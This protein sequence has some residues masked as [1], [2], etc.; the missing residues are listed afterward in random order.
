MPDKDDTPPP[1]GRPGLARRLAESLRASARPAATRPA[2]AAGLRTATATVA[3]LVVG[4][5]LGVPHA[6]WAGIAGFLVSRADGGGAYR[7]RARA[8]GS[9]ALAAAFAAASA[10][11]ASR[12]PAAAVPAVLV[13]TVAASLARAYGAAAG[14][15]GVM[16]SVLFVVSLSTPVSAPGEPLERA[17]WVLAG[18]AWAM[19][20]SLSFWP[21]R[22]YRPAVLAVA[23]CYRNLS[24]YAA[25]LAR[26]AEGGGWGGRGS[27]AFLR[28]RKAVEEARV[29]L[30]AIRRGR[31]GENVRGER[32]LV[33][34]ETADRVLATL[35][36]LGDVLEGGAADERAEAERELAR[37]AAAL[38]ECASLVESEGRTPAVP[39][40]PEPARLTAG[41]A[42]TLLSRLSEFVRAAMEIAEGF[43]DGRPVPESPVSTP[44]LPAEAR[45]PL[46]PLRES[47]AP[48]SALL[49]HALRAGITVAAAVGATQALGLERGYWVTLTVL[50]VLQPYTG[51]T[52]QRAMERALGTM[53]G[54]IIAAGIA[55]G[56]HDPRGILALVFVLAAVS[57]AVFPINAVLYL[58]FLTP[59]F[60]LLAEVS[61]GEWH[62]AGVRVA[63]TFLGGL[64]AL[65]GAALLWPTPERDRLPAEVAAVLRADRDYLHAAVERLGDG[66]EAAVARVIAA[67]RR[68]G[69]AILNAEAWLEQ[70]ASA[71]AGRTDELESW[72]TLL[73]YGRRLGGSLA[74][75]AILG[76]QGALGRGEAE[77][78]GAVAERVLDDLADA[79][80]ARRPP[81]PLPP[82]FPPAGDPLLRAQLERVAG[83]L[84]VL[85]DAARR[86]RTGGTGLA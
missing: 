52:V 76:G 2:V 8:M 84:G 59:T 42:G 7:T 10:A 21:V 40:P 11:Y 27:S 69:A 77:A 58:V 80:E 43:R 57:V 78:F 82:P 35:V 14:T 17:A 26:P 20:L 67:R 28:A 1:P 31:F 4:Y 39:R 49:R 81:A 25:E 65:V 12:Y 63:D 74:A 61:T 60:V 30:A 85:H 62:L 86:L 71:P 44:R 29:T 51:A 53:L 15:L 79:L 70:L 83:Q 22:F 68:L 24:D 19:L 38:R 37:F 75:L 54:G 3:P 48:E 16:A 34:L 6:M 47:L 56:V 73:A 72:M 46:L 23:A 33:L 9:L 64:L 13:W 32:V 50:I 55:V 5:L 41:L 45:D 18:G 66:G 36:A